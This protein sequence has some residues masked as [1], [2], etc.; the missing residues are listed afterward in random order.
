M[1]PPLPPSPTDVRV[2]SGSLRY[3]VTPSP[4]T[5]PLYV[6]GSEGN[7]NAV[8]EDSSTGSSLFRSGRRLLWPGSGPALETSMPNLPGLPLPPTMFGRTPHPS[9]V[10]DLNLDLDQSELTLQPTGIPSGSPRPPGTL[11]QFRPVSGLYLIGP[12]GLLLPIMRL[13]REWNAR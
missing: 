2:S 4:L 5:A 3:P 1:A 9:P 11:W 12:F 6:L 8:Q 13:L 7:W 10:R